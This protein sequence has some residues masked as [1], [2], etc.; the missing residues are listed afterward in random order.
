MLGDD[1][2]ALSEDRLRLALSVELMDMRGMHG[3]PR[4]PL[5]Y[6]SGIDP[7]PPFEGVDPNDRVP[8]V[9][10]FADGSVALLNVSDEVVEVEGPGGLEMIRGVRAEAGPRILEPG[11]G[12]LWVP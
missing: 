6:V 11:A 10:D 4:D 12:E 5:S 7:G 3:H 2:P 8:V 9:W 1:L